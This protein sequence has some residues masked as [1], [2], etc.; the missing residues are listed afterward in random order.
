M[1]I[2]KLGFSP[3]LFDAVFAQA[4]LLHIPKSKIAKVLTD[5]NQILKSRGLFYISLKKGRGEVIL[6]E[7]Y[8][9]TEKLKRFL[10]L[11]SRAEFRRLLQETG[12]TVVYESTNPGRTHPWLNFLARR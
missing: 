3:Q 6:E 8:Y 11:Y 7:D 5:I 2:E 1:D 12:F 9:N 4:S 10:A